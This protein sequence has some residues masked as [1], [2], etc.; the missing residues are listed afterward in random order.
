MRYLS[1]WDAFVIL[2]LMSIFFFPQG[3]YPEERQIQPTILF[4]F[5]GD[6]A[7]VDHFELHWIPVPGSGVIEF[8]FNLDDTTTREWE[9]PEFGMEPGD[10]RPFYLVAVMSDG[11]KGWSMYH[12]FMF[13]GEPFIIAVEKGEVL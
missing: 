8:L 5:A 6:P 9:T 7:E 4:S 13:T 12:D 3:A 11:R 10:V 2:L 1:L